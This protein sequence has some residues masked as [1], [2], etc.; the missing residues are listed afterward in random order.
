MFNISFS[1]I[2]SKTTTKTKREHEK[3][4]VIDARETAPLASTAHMFRDA[5]DKTKG[6]LSVAVP[7]EIKGYWQ[8]HQL[9]GK[10]PWNRLFQPAIEMCTNG[11]HLP[12]SQARFVKYCET[13][14]LSSVE[15]RECYFNSIK[16]E[17]YKANAVLRRPKLA[18]TFE[19]LARE[20]ADAFYNGSLTDTIVHEIQTNGGIITRH[21]LQSYECLVKEPI[22]YMLK[23]G[24]L[25]NTVPSPSCGTLL[26][27]ILA[28]LDCECFFNYSN[29]LSDFSIFS[30]EQ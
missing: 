27:F 30:K 12:A 19:V 24:V 6:G 9:F 8:A 23:N 21:D 17:L 7:G 15:L 29:I 20:G 26:N 3:I 25:L 16:N 13:K 2:F 14:I 1:T 22:S 28:L 18:K 11:F 5:S 10:L 4:T